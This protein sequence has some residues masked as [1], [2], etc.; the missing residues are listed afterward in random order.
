M[1]VSGDVYEKFFVLSS[2]FVVLSFCLSACAPKAAIKPAFVMSKVHRV[3]VLPFDGNGGPSVANE[4]I[5]QLLANGFEVS[6]RT[7]GVDAVLS[8][9]V[10]VYKPGDKLMVVLGHTTTVNGAGQTVDVANPVV[11]LNGSQVTAG[12]PSMPNSQ[13]VAVNASVE[14]TAKLSHAA[15][16]NV[17]WG[18]EFSYEGLEVQDAVQVVV[19]SLVKSLHRMITQAG[20]TLPVKPVP[21]QGVKN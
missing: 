15:S 20:R 17:I 11:S 13:I 10:T 5:R 1:N 2:Q 3:A 16:G 12:S 8:G 7:Q 21:V 19:D 6:D 14:V 9:A 18:D 4:F